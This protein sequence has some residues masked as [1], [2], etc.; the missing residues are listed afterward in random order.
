MI[1]THH[2]YDGFRRASDLVPPSLQPQ[3]FSLWRFVRSCRW[4]T[5]HMHAGAE[6]SSARAQRL[7]IFCWTSSDQLMMTL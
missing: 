6:S 4:L 3:A 1:V 2:H 5:D 7:D